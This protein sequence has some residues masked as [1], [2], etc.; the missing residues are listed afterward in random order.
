MELMRTEVVFMSSTT[1][2]GLINPALL[3]VHNIV[4]PL[5]YRPF[6]TVSS[7]DFKPTNVN[8]EI[9][10]HSCLKYMMCNSR[11]LMGGR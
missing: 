11:N 4:T 10:D 7:L 3:A 5:D 1:L 9:I 2:R 6:G 8:I